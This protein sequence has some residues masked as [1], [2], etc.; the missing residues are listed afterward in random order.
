M[1]QK[2]I[3]G[4][5]H[6]LVAEGVGQVTLRRGHDVAVLLHAQLLG[7]GASHVNLLL[8]FTTAVLQRND[9]SQ[10]CV[11]LHQG[12]HD[13]GVVSDLRRGLD[14]EHIE[15]NAERDGAHAELRHVRSVQAVDAVGPQN[16]SLHGGL[17]IGSAVSPKQAGGSGL[18]LRR[19]RVDLGLW[20]AA[21][22]GRPA[23]RPPRDLRQA[24]DQV[25]IP[26][27][28]EV[29]EVQ[30][31]VLHALMRPEVRVDVADRVPV[32]PTDQRFPLLRGAGVFPFPKLDQVE[33]VDLLAVPLDQVR[34]VPLG[35][36]V[37]RM[38]M[39]FDLYGRLRHRPVGR[40]RPEGRD[41]AADLSHPAEL[42]LMDPLLV[43]DLFHLHVVGHVPCVVHA[44]L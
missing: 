35:C 24:L 2:Q 20:V 28:R 17:E 41:A 37:R 33:Q 40:L 5:L 16:T 39:L 25:D 31:N 22:Q 3:H 15:L 29:A 4:A 7:R 32:V 21:E 1:P 9:V 34:K 10:R 43:Q 8:G 23:Q 26:H 42:S 11:H 18:G 30:S 19:I 44:S 38:I 36:L 27:F 13:G 14:A 12:L 6:N